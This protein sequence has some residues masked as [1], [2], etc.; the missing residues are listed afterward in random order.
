MQRNTP[1]KFW[2]R[3][4][5]VDSGC[6]EWQGGVNSGGY[7]SLGWHGK[8][9]TA[10]RIAA[11]LAGMIRSPRAPIRKSTK[12]FVLHRCDNR[13]C[14]NPDHLFIGNYSDNTKD[15]Y[16]KKR[17]KITRGEESPVSKLTNEQARQ[18][19]LRLGK[20]ERKKDLALEYSITTRALSNLE[21]GKTYKD[22]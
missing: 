21:S 6:W 9:Y 4:K 20:G 2:S 16:D 5:P 8:P 7:G 15:A 3:V 10:H 1:E 17:R 14:C 19:R 13:L 22:A 12:G 11:W 18:I